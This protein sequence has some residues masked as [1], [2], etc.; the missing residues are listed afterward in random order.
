MEAA[1]PGRPTS[2]YVA[3]VVRGYTKETLAQRIA[4][5]LKDYEPEDIIS[6]EVFCDPWITFFWRRNSAVITLRP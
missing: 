2:S 5:R 6:I 1:E 4:E 3:F